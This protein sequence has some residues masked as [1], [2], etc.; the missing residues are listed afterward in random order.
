MRATMQK[1]TADLR[2]RERRGAVAGVRPGC[3]SASAW[4]GHRRRIL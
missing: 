1:T 2:A 4:H 3:E